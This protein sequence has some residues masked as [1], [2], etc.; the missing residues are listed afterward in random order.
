MAINTFKSLRDQCLRLLDEAGDTSTTRDLLKDLINQAHQMR[1]MSQPWNFM[2]QEDTFTCTV[3][4]QVYSL[5]QEF[6]KALYFFNRTTKDYLREVPMRTLPATGARW[7]TD[8]GHPRSFTLWG[9][10]PVQNQPTSASTVSISSS[11]A[12]DNTATYAVIVRGINSSGVLLT[13]SITPNGATPVA[14][15]NSYTR[16]VGVTKSA[17]WNGTLTMTSNSAAV[18]NLTLLAAEYGRSYQQIF[19]L[20]DPTSADVIE[21]RHLKQ[22]LELVYDYDIPDI[23][24]PHAQV[25]V[26]DALLLYAPYCSDLDAKAV[27]IW[28]GMQKRCEDVMLATLGEGETAEAH[29]RYVRVFSDDDDVNVPRVY[30]S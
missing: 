13:E 23:P 28:G 27:T 16:L 22:P 6:G 8:T 17:A 19:L 21:Y 9:R 11:S 1:C 5:N 4:Q 12:S 30:Q 24:P 29:P 10:S 14:S 7:N 20:E 18:T 25:L 26:W 2:V 15:S 3:G